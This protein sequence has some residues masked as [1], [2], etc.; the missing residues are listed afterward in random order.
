MPLRM[1]VKKRQEITSISKFMEK[2]KLSYTVDGNVKL[3]VATKEKI[4]EILQKKKKK[5][6]E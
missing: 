4:M 6:R 3:S 1:A 5:K 2:R